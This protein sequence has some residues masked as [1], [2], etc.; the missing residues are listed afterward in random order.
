MKIFCSFKVH[1]QSALSKGDCPKWSDNLDE[2]KSKGF[3]DSRW[4]QWG[5]GREIYHS[6]ELCPMDFWNWLAHSHN[7]LRQSHVINIEPTCSVSLVEPWLIFYCYHVHFT[8]RETE[9]V[10]R[11]INLSKVSQ[12]VLVYKANNPNCKSWVFHTVAFP[13]QKLT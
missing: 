11:L 3:C 13:G 1:H 6:F 12:L 10:K 9:E 8:D 5:R 7:C 4:G 2:F